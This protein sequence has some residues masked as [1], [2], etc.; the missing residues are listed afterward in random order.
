MTD[1]KRPPYSRA[2]AEVDPARRRVIKGFAAGSLIPLLGG[3]ML[4]C[5]GSSGSA[6][7]LDAGT[8]AGFLH[9]V[10][11]GDPLE[12]RVIIW[13]RATPATTGP[14]QLRWEVA[15]DEAFTDVVASGGG[16][17]SAATDYTAKV[18]VDGLSPGASYFYRFFTGDTAS[19]VGRTKT[20]PVG[21]IESVRLAVLSCANYPAGYFNVYR[22]VANAELDAVLHLGDYI[23][24]YGA[25]G[26]A[27][28]RAE[29]FGR[30]PEPATELLSL[31]DY[32]TRY[33]QYRGDVDLQAAHAAHPFIVVWDDHE[34]TNDAWRQGAENHQ[35]D[36]EGDYRERVA[37]A[38]QAYY[39]WMPIRPPAEDR[40][41]IYRQFK[42]GD[43]VDLL[44][45]D[46]RLIGRDQQVNYADFN[47]EEG[48]D[49]P[50]A[51]AAIADSDRT[52][53]GDAQNAW[54]KERLKSSTATWQALGQQLL[55]GR[56]TLPVSAIVS[57]D[58]R[59]LDIERGRAAVVSTAEAKATPPQQRTP[60]QQQ[61]V[62]SLVPYN[63]D[64]WD[65]YGANQSELMDAARAAGS[66]LVAFA[67]DTHNAWASQLKDSGGNTVGVE[68]A[69]A[70]VSSPGI[71]GRVTSEL[72]L[73]LEE[74]FLT[75]ID[76]L[77]Y[78][79]LTDRGYLTVEFTEQAVTGSWR[80]VSTIHSKD[81]TLLD[82]RAHDITL[83][84]DDL[85]LS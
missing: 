18:D 44:M 49:L 2:D 79:N 29:E 20:L 60:E 83:Q 34:I 30:V 26:Y 77:H 16:V 36:T 40:E 10:A 17:T 11:S 47:S 69:T 70:S 12:N 78:V 41:I 37:A 74:P 6:S 72:A 63:T 57:L 42:Y 22:E 65:G 38:L 4:G 39:E 61:L 75:L 35:P 67:G 3:N 33:G 48:F 73:E 45:L 7:D 15:T 1:R 55:M 46:T 13:T 8:A 5:A 59:N 64:A 19:P 27:T 50:S 54:L 25:S 32:R 85:R 28:A 14:V 66:R 71:D 23:Y 62:A 43:L 56:Y 53:L 9:G 82:G 84:A 51:M 24:E 81:Y 58:Y 52:L 31:S 68:F 21:G 76:D 80:Y